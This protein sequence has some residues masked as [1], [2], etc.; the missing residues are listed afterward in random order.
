MKCGVNVKGDRYETMQSIMQYN[1]IHKIFSTCSMR[2]RIDLLLL[3]L[4]KDPEQKRALTQLAQQAAAAGAGSRDAGKGGSLLVE[5][6]RALLNSLMY[7]LGVITV[8]PTLTVRTCQTLQEY[9]KR[10]PNDSL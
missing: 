10:M 6:A 9:A 7:M 4:W 8:S 5:Y 3:E 2:H 1:M